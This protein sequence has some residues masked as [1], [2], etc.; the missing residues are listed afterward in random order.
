[1][2]IGIQMPGIDLLIAKELSLELKKNLD[3]NVLRK[4]ER[5]LFLEHGMSIK[6]S[7]EHFENFHN[8]LK[9]NSQIEIKNFEKNCCSKIL[10]VKPL[11]NKYLLKIINQNLAEKI[12]NFFGDVE[13]RKLLQCLMKKNQTISQILKKS[14][15]LKSP[16]YRKM[17]NLLLDGLVFESGKILENNKRIS[18]YGCIFDEIRTVVN[19]EGLILEGT[20][21][22]ANFKKSSIVKMGIL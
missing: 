4:I 2:V 21:S 16:A 20:V 9:K 8:I 5:E 18:Q 10:E 15:V 17:E 13:S 19:D 12:F 1:M 7:I 14:T 11:K 22:S 3:K 6:L